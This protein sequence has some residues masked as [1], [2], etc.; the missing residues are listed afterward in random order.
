MGGRAGGRGIK[1]PMEAQPTHGSQ[2]SQMQVPEMYSSQQQQQHGKIYVH[3]IC[4]Y[5]QYPS[6]LEE[7]YLGAVFLVKI[8]KIEYVWKGMI[9]VTI[10]VAIEQELEHWSMFSKMLS[11]KTWRSH[12]KNYWATMFHHKII[13]TSSQ[14]KLHENWVQFL[15]SKDEC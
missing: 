7:S 14:F 5:T 6:F 10:K 15:H 13:A 1:G 8:C 9:E 11:R 4:N 3:I 12:D 2:E